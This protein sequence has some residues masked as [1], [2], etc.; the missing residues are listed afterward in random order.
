MST[1]HIIWLSSGDV[2]VFIGGEGVST[3][4]YLIG[5]CVEVKVGL[6]G[7]GMRFRRDS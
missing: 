4:V 5:I 2:V 3:L 1:L 7:G 6:G